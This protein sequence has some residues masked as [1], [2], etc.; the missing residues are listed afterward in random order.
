MI[1]IEVSSL[2]KSYGNLKA[3]DKISFSVKEGEVFAL[4]GPNGAGK[5]TAIE[6]LEGLRKKNGGEV[7]VLGLDPWKH[8]YE[9]H[10]RIGIIP[11]DFTFFE[12]A[13]LKKL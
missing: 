10:R 3:V 7:Y 5:T 2:E 6:I 8:G 1:P 4:L 13:R 11:Q 12:K 9:L